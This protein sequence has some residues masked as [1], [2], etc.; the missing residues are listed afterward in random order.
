MR[1]IWITSATLFSLGRFK[2]ARENSNGILESSGEITLTEG[3]V[4]HR[5]MSNGEVEIAII[6]DGV[7]PTA[8]LPVGLPSPLP[9]D[10]VDALKS[11]WSSQR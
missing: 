9:A 10:V 1:D 3:E 6:F 5:E 2:P 8:R 4:F 7:M 11:C